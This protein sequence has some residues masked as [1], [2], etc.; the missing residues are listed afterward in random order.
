MTRS[1]LF[2]FKLFFSQDF[3]ILMW[4]VL[5]SS[6][7]LLLNLLVIFMFCF[8]GH[9]ACGFYLPEQRLNPHLRH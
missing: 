1:D 7:N 8:F 9:E 2:F 6:L 5:K 3:F 4:T